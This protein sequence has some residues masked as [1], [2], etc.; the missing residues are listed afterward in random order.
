MNPDE[1]TR[2]E[3]RRIYS[4]EQPKPTMRALAERFGL[5]KNRVWKILNE[6]RPLVTPKVVEQFRSKV[7]VNG[8]VHPVLKTACHVWTARRARDGYGIFGFGLKT[9]QAHRVAWFLTHGRWPSPVALHKC[10]NPPCVRVDHLFE[11]TIADNVRDMREKGRARGGRLTGER[12]GSAKVSDAI[13]Q[14]IKRLAALGRY[15]HRE[16][17][18]KFKLSTAHVWNIVNGRSR[19]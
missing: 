12:H 8:P 10:D 3:I 7:D 6:D 11:G 4:E 17:A 16:I 1:A 13:A 9:E 14:E 2:A 18:F 15:T 19:K 5:S